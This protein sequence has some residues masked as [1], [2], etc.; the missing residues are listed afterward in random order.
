MKKT[1]TLNSAQRWLWLNWVL[2]AALGTG[3]GALAQY[4]FSWLYN[5]APVSNFLLALAPSGAGAWEALFNM[6]GLLANNFI[7]AL[8]GWFVIKPHLRYQRAWLWAAGLGLWIT[9]TYGLVG[10]Y[11]NQA[12]TQAWGLF[13]SSL[14]SWATFIAA[15]LVT[16]LALRL[17]APRAHR[18]LI[19]TAIGYVAS[20]GLYTL[21]VTIAL[22]DTAS[23]LYL[24][25]AN[26]SMATTLGLQ[27]GLA[28][29]PA[30][31]T[32]LGL[33]LILAGDDAEAEKPLP[34]PANQ[35]MLKWVLYTLL[36]I[37][38]WRLV[39]IILALTG[40]TTL[41]SSNKWV[42]VGFYGVY[43]AWMAFFQW[44]V[45]KRWIKSGW[46][47]IA[48]T[49]IGG[50]IGVFLTNTI[51]LQAWISTSALA[52]AIPQDILYTLLSYG[53]AWLLMAVLQ[54][55]C[56][57]GWVGWSGLTWILWGFLAF[58]LYA[59]FG[60]YGVY[61]LATAG[62]LRWL[63]GSV[64]RQPILA[65]ITNTRLAPDAMKDTAFALEGRIEEFFGSKVK[66]DTSVDTLEASAVDSKKLDDSVGLLLMPGKVDLYFLPAVDAE[67]TEIPSIITDQILGADWLVDDAAVEVELHPSLVEALAQAV[68]D[69]RYVC[70]VVDGERVVTCPVEVGELS[71]KLRLS[72]FADPEQACWLSALCNTDPLPSALTQVWY[73]DDNLIDDDTEE[74]IEDEIEEDTEETGEDHSEGA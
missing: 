63:L 35:F 6:L 2:A 51:D 65:L 19:W 72:G 45:L 54:A 29:I 46:M 56:L 13:F 64:L 12:Q 25:L 4:G 62:I 52:A 34:N 27:A 74:E 44:L 21:L 20:I 5:W 57:V 23:P 7:I 30:I 60:N 41:I 48:A 31:F 61:A 28:L 33:A 14:M 70:A 1:F 69:N 36:S 38:S 53:F 8:A 71:N 42:L 18:W 16:W 68:N 55:A 49:F 15:A 11:M 58:V 10:N 40:L 66:L 26:Q 17:E 32:G 47:W 37:I 67:L 59:L 22:K 73:D 24:F 50:A 9:L 39:T 43:Y 3:L